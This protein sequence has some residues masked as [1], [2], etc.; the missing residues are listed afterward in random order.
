[1]ILKYTCKFSKEFNRDIELYFFEI[2]KP[3]YVKGQT[4]KCL[5]LFIN[6]YDN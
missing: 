2:R 3:V 1:M 4:Y 5:L 6:G